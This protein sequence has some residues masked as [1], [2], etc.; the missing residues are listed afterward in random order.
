MPSSLAL[1]SATPS[2][3]ALPPPLRWGVVTTHPQAE[4]WAA[5]NLNRAGYPAWF[6]TYAARVRDPVLRT[7]S[8][9]VERPLF[10]GYVF[11]TLNGPWTPIR[12]AP[13]V[14]ELLMDHDHPSVC[15][16]EAIEALQAGED[17]RRTPPAPGAAW[18]VG[19]PCRLASGPFQS[20]PAVIVEVRGENARIS[21]L[22]LGALRSV[23]VPVECLIPREE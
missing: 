1:A 14:R 2:A 12:Y 23:Y 18:A 7:L 6:P 21:L 19:T 20:H 15:P 3:D 9:I 11:V 4:Q 8:R 17:A 5:A 22:L 16:T 10:P 13:G